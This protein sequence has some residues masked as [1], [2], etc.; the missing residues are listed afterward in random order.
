MLFAAKNGLGGHSRSKTPKKSTYAP[1]SSSKKDN[2]RFETG[3]KDKKDK[4]TGK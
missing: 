4:I 3:Q 1:T 2:S